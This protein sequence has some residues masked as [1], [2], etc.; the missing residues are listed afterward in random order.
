MIDYDKLKEEIDLIHKRMYVQK[1]EY[2]NE[3]AKA[4]CVSIC[5]SLDRIYTCLNEL[6]ARDVQNE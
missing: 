6:I 5:Q 3:D 1:D 2:L 4:L